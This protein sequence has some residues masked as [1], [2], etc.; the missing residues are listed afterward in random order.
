M[1]SSV[2]LDKWLW[3]ARFFKTRSLAREAVKGGKVHLRGAR[4]KP[5]KVL[6]AGD[7]LT[8]RR[9]EELFEITVDDVGDRRLSPSLAR[10]KYTEDPDSLANRLALAEARKREHQAKVNRPRRPD[11]RQRRNIVNFKRA[12]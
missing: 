9:G 3:A 10:D 5:G 8:I 11:K 2:R 6:G 4:V 12:D 7:R 1:D